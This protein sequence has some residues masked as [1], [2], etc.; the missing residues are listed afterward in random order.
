MLC[1]R[2]GAL[3]ELDTRY[4][5]QCGE[6][7]G[8]RAGT[9]PVWSDT[10]VA[11]VGGSSPPSSV[12]WSD[13]ASSPEGVPEWAATLTQVEAPSPEVQAAHAS[14][15]EVHPVSVPDPPPVSQVA[16]W[17]G[18]VILLAIGMAVLVKLAIAIWVVGEK[19][20]VFPQNKSGLETHARPP[21]VI[22]V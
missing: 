4:C 13:Q 5:K 3:V 20:R 17:L 15:A 2:C 22:A 14:L 9:P 21:I 18:V 12:H 11:A 16:R 8:A 6:E 1:S 7:T 19:S 10:P